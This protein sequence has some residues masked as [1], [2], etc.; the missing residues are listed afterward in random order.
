MNKLNLR[1]VNNVETNIH[2]LDGLI[3]DCKSIIPDY[4][5]FI[6]ITDQNIYNHYGQLLINQ[7][8]NTNYKIITCPPGEQ[9]KSLNY[10]ENIYSDLINFKCDRQS[11]IVAFGG[12]AIGDM[13]G[14]VASTFMRG[15]DYINIPTTL[16]SMID[17]SIGGKSGVNLTAGKNLIGSIYHPK[18]IIIDP[19]LLE[20]LPS[21][22]YHSGMA[23]MIKYGLILSKE[24]FDTLEKHLEPILSDLS[25]PINDL[26]VNCIDLKINIVNQD[27]R[28]YGIR[29]ILNF[30][31]TI[32][33][34][35]EA[36]LGNEYIRHGEAVAYGMLY[37]AKLSNVKGSLSNSDLKRVSK[38]IGK[39]ELPKLKNIDINRILSFIKNDKKN[40]S[41]DLKFI[42]LDS[43][44]KA[45]VSQQIK[46]DDIKMV[47]EENEY[48]SN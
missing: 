7:F 32:G 28:D 29:N 36:C 11:C 48:I 19:K 16:L 6:I 13:S 34:A 38:L 30:G 17:S 23:E 46:Y 41:Q 40:I 10:V 43:I 24:L 15:I 20:T 25:I 39:L 9:I 35:L 2:I 26:I 31:H 21:R 14:F 8:H 12:G 37:A 45:Y 47:L 22:E 1:L 27:V 5:Q 18:Q 33:H 44:G 42:L 4:S 3:N